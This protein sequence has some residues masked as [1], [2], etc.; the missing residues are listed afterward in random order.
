MAAR[1]ARGCVRRMC[2]RATRKSRSL[3][4]HL[5][6]ALPSTE[7]SGCQQGHRAT[8][9]QSGGVHG[10]LDQTVAETLF[11][12]DSAGSLRRGG[13]AEESSGAQ[14]GPGRE[15]GTAY[16]YVRH[17]SDIGSRCLRLNAQLG[18]SRR[19]SYACRCGPARSGCRSGPVGLP[20]AHRKPADVGGR[21]RI[22]HWLSRPGAVTPT[23][24][25]L[26]VPGAA[27]R[28]N[29]ATDCRASGPASRG[30]R[31]PLS[32]ERGLHPEAKA[33]CM[34]A[35]D[36]CSRRWPATR[37]ST[38]PALITLTRCSRRACRP[39]DVEA[40]LLHRP[41]GLPAAPRPPGFL[42]PA[43][44]HPNRGPD[45][46]VT[47]CGRLRLVGPEAASRRGVTRQDFA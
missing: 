10:Q 35:S 13:S 2:D 36:S 28:P 45:R 34:S 38:S 42:A 9:A 29:E 37:W 7:I 17:M 24:G 27:S 21:A 19:H 25:D 40:A 33:N 5:G 12:Q 44:R 43:T 18:R 14:H 46:F 11:G 41:G 16:P 31:R 47:V 26:H 39:A 30:S 20:A 8:A 3:C 32:T 22:A 23:N 1:P 15:N 4:A 6:S